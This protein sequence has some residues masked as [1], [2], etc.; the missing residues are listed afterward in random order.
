MSADNWGIC[1][2]C[3]KNFKKS[4]PKYGEVSEAEY[5]NFV[6]RE[7]V[8]EG[9]PEETLREDFS[10]GTD[11]QGEFAIYYKCHC[12]RCGF[13]FKFN[14]KEQLITEQAGALDLSDKAPPSK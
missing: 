1:P 6:N 13:K 8:Q 3:V 9:Y 12:D 11:K 4:K 7:E 5:L 2:Q 10:I 14:H